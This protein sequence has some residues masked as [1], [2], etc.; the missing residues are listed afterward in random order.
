MQNVIALIAAYNEENAIGLTINAIKRISCVTGILV[1]DDG[2]TDQTAKKA[3]EAGAVVLS[4]ANNSGKGAALSYGIHELDINDNDIVLLL[5]ADLKESAS[6]AE[7]LLIPIIKNKADYTVAKFQKSNSGGGFGIVKSY[8]K[9]VGKLFNAPSLTAPLSGQR[10]TTF[11]IMKTMV[12]ANN[13]GCELSQNIMLGKIRTTVLEVDTN[14]VN[15]PTGKTLKGFLHRG[16]QLRD[17]F[18]TTFAALFGRNGESAFNG[19]LKIKRVLLWLLSIAVFFILI[20]KTTPKTA[21]IFGIF[22]ALIGPFFAVV[23]SIVMRVFKQNYAG[24]II[25]ALG[26]LTFLPTLLLFQVIVLVHLI[27]ANTETNVLILL[28]PLYGILWLTIGLSD[29]LFGNTKH[30]GFKGHIIALCHGHITS[31]AIK[32]I[33]GGMLS[34]LAAYFIMA[35]DKNLN[36][37]WI[38]ISAP[39]I[40]LSANTFNL[41]DLRPGRTLKVWWTSVFVIL[42]F[43]G[44]TIINGTTIWHNF[45][46]LGSV[47]LLIILTTILY[48][49]LDFSSQMMLGD[50]GSNLLGGLLGA[51]IVI[52]ANPLLQVF[53]L[54]VFLAVNIYSEKK[55]LSTTISNNKFLSFIDNLGR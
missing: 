43:A 54:I 1:I 46:P 49:P 38:F 35:L 22:F 44:I 50:T 10:A 12:F 36:Y 40:A 34:L 48:A 16:R 41:L 18:S 30:K 15:R 27:N 37:W 7:K 33:G 52:T 39:L 8:A 5:D 25:P 45:Y 9:N 47:F 26:G 55:S 11:G 13:Y 42:I 19:G 3:E 2:S 24:K 32:L 23:S 17:L 6:E 4:I 20:V 28:A 14:M 51:V 21:A 29:D 31:G 53:I